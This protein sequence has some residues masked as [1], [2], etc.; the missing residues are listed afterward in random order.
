[1]TQVLTQ[2]RQEQDT[3]VTITELQAWVANKQEWQALQEL[4]QDYSCGS[5]RAIFEFGRVSQD[6]DPFDKSY[7]TLTFYETRPKCTFIIPDSQGYDEF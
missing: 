7:G 3:Q 4:Q 2:V 6:M 1:M 5:P